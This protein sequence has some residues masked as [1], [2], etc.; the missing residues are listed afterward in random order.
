MTTIHEALRAL[1]ALGNRVYTREP[2]AA[3]LEPYAVVEAVSAGVVLPLHED[4]HGRARDLTSTTV[5][6]A[7]YGPAQGEPGSLQD[8]FR[9]AKDARWSVDAHPGLR[10]CGRAT[11]GP[12][13]PPV[14]D[15]D[16]KRPFASLQFSLT[17]Q[18]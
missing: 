3:P 18:E 6:V 15:R 16:A 5:R 2:D 1:P 11:L 10:G 13:L 12:A 7:L 14:Y 4:A 17:S 9:A 8:L